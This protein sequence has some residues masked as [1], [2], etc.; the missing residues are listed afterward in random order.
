MSS[1]RITALSHAP[2]KGIALVLVAVVI[3]ASMDTVGKYL[4]TKFNV[5]LVAAVRYGLN[6]LILTALMA[7]KHGAVLWH[8]QRTKLVWLRGASLA[9]ATFFAGLSLQRLPVGEAVSIFYLQGFGVMLAAGYV[10]NEKVGMA[11]WF[12]AIFGFAGVVLIARPGGNLDVLGVLFA[13]ICAAVSII[14]ILLSRVLATTESTMAMLFYVALSGSILFCVLLLFDWQNFS[15]TTLD[16]I[17]LFYV[18]AAS[19]LAHFLLT[20]AYRFAPASLLAPFNYFH[21]AFAVLAGWI[22][23]NHIPDAWALSGMAMIAIS[24]AA[25]ALHTHLTKA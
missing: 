15:Y 24:G 17:L 5:P 18:G 12:A 19:L 16:L 25:I 22:V 4:M 1:R 2:I 20:S 8:T 14:Y 10:L 11:G 9:L 13:F 21:I 7:P 3:F 6:L 23:Y